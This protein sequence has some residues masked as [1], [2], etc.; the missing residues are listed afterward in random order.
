MSDAVL[1]LNAG[2]SS[3]KF[4]LYGL[5]RDGG[6]RLASHGHIE[7]IGTAPHFLALDPSGARLAER[8]WAEDAAQTH[9]ALLGVLLDWVDSHLGT[10]VLVA[11]GHRVVHGGMEFDRPARV[12][13]GLLDALE[14]LTPLAPL[15]QPH[16]VSP[17]RAIA[18][19]RPGLPQ[20]AC[21]D[22]AFHR[23]MPEVATRFGLP[24]EY[25]AEGVRRY[26]FHGLSYEYVAGR[27]REI[28]PALAGER[29]IAAHL[30]NGASLCAMRE[31][32]SIDTTMGFSTLDGLVMGTRCGNLDPG[33]V[34]Y[35]QQSHGMDAGRITD[36]LYRRSG[37][38]GVSGLS[39]DMR[40][41]LA[42]T[43]PHAV[44]A[45]ELFAYCAAREIGGLASSLGGLDLLV[46]TAGI[47]EHAWQI[48][49]MICD[50][51]GWLGVTLDQWANAADAGVISTGPSRVEV[52]V[53]ATDEEAMIA[54]HTR[55][56]VR[57][58]CSSAA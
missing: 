37:L 32:R 15:H 7:G 57:G 40:D 29:V 34:V 55:D 41:L 3:I 46:F 25:H 48:R 23:T 5:G 6:L 31:G 35:L 9:E 51:L 28:A 12:T 47:G 53:V 10:A 49:R 19:L 38:L 50:R 39:S 18:A 8:R 13:P 14:R 2:S 52:R 30:G 44:E 1:T 27:L 17:I 24:R 36:L 56:V 42:S 20:V 11:A 43:A 33:V 54:R 16:N 58:S 45:V 21:F 4:G 26:G 22:T